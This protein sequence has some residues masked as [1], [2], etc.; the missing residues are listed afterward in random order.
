MNQF[1][2][3]T[4]FTIPGPP[5]G[6]A[7]ARTVR[8]NGF[9]HSYTPEKTVLYEN[10]VKTEYEQAGGIYHGGTVQISLKIV[11]YYPIRKGESKCNVACMLS[12]NTRPTKKPDIS[13]VLKI[14]EDALNGVAYK[15]DA[16]IVHNETDKFYGEVPRVEVEIR[17]L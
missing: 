6:K 17:E 10:L 8:N 9:T 16:Q 14:V 2:A 1:A 4:R 13:N 7:R 15:D 3:I 11:A 5:Q 12:G